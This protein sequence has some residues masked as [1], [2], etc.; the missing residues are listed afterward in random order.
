MP[1]ASRTYSR[2]K[3]PASARTAAEARHNEALVG[4]RDRLLEAEQQ[5][6]DAQRS[7]YLAHR[8]VSELGGQLQSLRG[9]LESAQARGLAIDIHAVHSQSRRY[10]IATDYEKGVGQW[11]KIRPGP[12]A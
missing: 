9:R 8:G 10:Q 1:L 2:T 12:G 4:L 3:K 6:E 5:R 7:M 11:V